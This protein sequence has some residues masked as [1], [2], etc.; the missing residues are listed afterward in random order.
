VLGVR[1]TNWRYLIP[2]L[3][4]LDLLVPVARTVVDRP[5]FAPLDLLW[6]AIV[7]MSALLWLRKVLV[8]AW[9]RVY[10]FNSGFI[11]AR[12]RR[13]QVYPYGE[14]V[15][16]AVWLPAGPARPRIRLRRGTGR[17]L[18]INQ[19][20]AVRAVSARVPHTRVRD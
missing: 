10:I 13:C 20:T 4:V 18:V 1:W 2:A 16:A 12:G 3:I 11:V 9:R 8:G 17:W 5:G 6:T 15:E 14:F 7:A 19:E